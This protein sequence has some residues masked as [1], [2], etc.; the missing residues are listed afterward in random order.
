MQ[1]DCF[2]KNCNY[3]IVPYWIMRPLVPVAK[4]NTRACSKS[5]NQICFTQWQHF[6]VC[7]SFH[8]LI[9]QIVIKLTTFHRG[10]LPL[11]QTC[12]CYQDSKFY[13]N[14][15]IGKCSWTVDLTSKNV[16]A[17]LK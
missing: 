11:P 1:Q 14:N 13:L 9:Y 2:Q 3:T 8:P 15:R 5:S 6:P 4:S 17:L 7:L 12:T 16:Y 10:N